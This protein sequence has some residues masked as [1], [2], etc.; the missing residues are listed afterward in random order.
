MKPSSIKT[1]RPI[2]PAEVKAPWLSVIS[3]TRLTGLGEKLIRQLPIKRF[4]KR[5]FASVEAI[6]ELILGNAPLIRNREV[7]GI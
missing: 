5:D 6:N 3:A 7:E 4:G 2:D 1:I